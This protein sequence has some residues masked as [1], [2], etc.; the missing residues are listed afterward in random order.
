MKVRCGIGLDI[1]GTHISAVA[2]DQRCKEASDVLCSSERAVT[3]RDVETVVG[4]IVECL[5]EVHGKL[6]EAYG[7]EFE[8]SGIG[9]G[10]PGNVDPTLGTTRY[11]PNFQW[12]ETVPL[13]DLVLKK[14]FSSGSLFG[15]CDA[16]RVRVEMRND[17]RCAA[18]AEFVFGYGKDCDGISVFS[19]LTLGTGI[20]GAVIIN[21]KL[22]DGA[23]FDAGD[24]GHHVIRSGEG[25]MPCVCG[26]AGCFETHASAQGLV[27]LYNRLPGAEKCCTGPD[28]RG[29][30]ALGV[31]KKL[32]AGDAV[33]ALAFETYADDLSSGLAN[34]VTFYNPN[35]IVLGGGFG[36]AEELYVGDEIQ[37][38]VDA[39]SLTATRG[40]VKVVRAVLGG[41]AGALGAAL[42]ALG[43]GV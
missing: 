29:H 1:G 2:L 33:A 42:L 20:G 23:S 37:R 14:L 9:F 30:D 26:K 34:L 21:G 15:H 13:K 32:R 38:R 41:G 5:I 36:Q 3:D 31:L 24:F 16:S 17:G 19:M 8:I 6:A 10:V 25:A 4:L 7:D 35:V 18:I 12:L 27:R 22:F 43:R 39:K 40:K 11:L 28:G